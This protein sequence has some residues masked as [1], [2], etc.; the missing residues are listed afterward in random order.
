MSLRLKTILGI[1][2]IEAILLIILISTVLNYMRTSSQERLASY[3]NTTTTLFA[4]MSKD[5]ILSFDLASLETFVE[6]ILKNKD[7]IYI[8]IYDNTKTLLSQGGEPSTLSKP[9]KEDTHY[10]G[11][12]DNIYDTQF[13]VTVDDEIYGRIEIGFS[14]QAIENDI[15][16]TMQLA[17]TI[18]AIEMVLVAL[19]S[20]ILGSYLTRQLKVLRVFSKKVAMGDLSQE[21]TRTSNDEVG[22]VAKSFNTMIKSLKYA[23]E[24]SRSYE[25]ELLELNKSLEDR[26]Q[27]RTEKVLE[28][29][30]KLQQ[31]Y[32]QLQLTQKQ[33]LQSEKM[34]SIGQLAAG[35]AH[36]INNPIAFVKS[37]LST[38]NSYIQSYQTLFTQYNELMALIDPS[39]VSDELKILLANIHKL[40]DEE[41]LEFINSDIEGLLT[42]SIDGTHR[43]QEIVRGLKTYAHHGEDTME[44][45]DINECL[46]N[47]LKM[48][49][50]ELKYKCEIITDLAEL[51]LLK[52]NRSKMAQVFT[53]L[54][55]NANHAIEKQ[56]IITVK[57]E[58]LPSGDSGHIS[59]NI[60]DTGKGIAAE[61]LSKLFDPFFTTKEVGEGTG[62]GLAISL[63]IINDHAG[64]IE[65]NSQVGK[66]TTFIITLPIN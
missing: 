42:E 62:L 3:I 23:Q 1:A 41:D 45:F 56:G 11:I 61:N 30:E 24:R 43:V 10:Q 39:H 9:F 38:L 53:N 46:Q 5:A 32:D 55:V 44:P 48:L 25:Q 59:I 28:Q 20:Y 8:K 2:F 60:S 22:E 66:G 6:E 54:L 21:I 15:N 31:A 57:S 52:G 18:A 47:T 49:N 26:V 34:A 36:E 37:N 29:K 4:T 63:G 16:T 65:V 13:N 17:A 40:L 58:F 50:N 14:I 33:L 7:I 27:Q 64:A 35:V 12:N 19:F 51:P